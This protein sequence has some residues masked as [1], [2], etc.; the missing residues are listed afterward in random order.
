M[1]TK[2]VER[3]QL[4]TNGSQNELLELIC[5]ELIVLGW[6]DILTGF[7]ISGALHKDI[8]LT[9]L[10]LICLLVAIAVMSIGGA[11]LACNS[12]ADS[13][14]LEDSEAEK[15]TETRLLVNPIAVGILLSSSA[16]LVAMIV[17]PLAAFLSVAIAITAFGHSFFT[18]LYPLYRLLN[19]AL[20]RAS[21][22]LLGISVIPNVWQQRWYVVLVPVIYLIIVVLYSQKNVGESKIPDELPILLLMLIVFEGIFLM[23]SNTGLG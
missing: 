22:I 2:N 13:D 23:Y 19:F 18:C 4:L 6:A 21:S 3:A 1:K 9:L 8:Q 7:A 20:Y 10:P 15:T 16:I 12:V 14:A 11:I 5:P 17:S